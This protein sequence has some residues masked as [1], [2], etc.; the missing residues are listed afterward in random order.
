MEDLFFKELGE[1][2][3]KFGVTPREPDLDK[4]PDSDYH[5]IRTLDLVW[6]LC[7]IVKP[8]EYSIILNL[9][10]QL[11]NKKKLKTLMLLYNEM[12]N[13]PE[14]SSSIFKDAPSVFGE[15]KVDEPDLGARELVEKFLEDMDKPKKKN[16]DFDAGAETKLDFVQLFLDEFC[17]INESRYIKRNITTK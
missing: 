7:D 10:N 6:M 15:K 11:E 3:K 9:F 4:V 16:F 13:L 5:D 8:D 14:R 17:S 12:I 2:T 1:L